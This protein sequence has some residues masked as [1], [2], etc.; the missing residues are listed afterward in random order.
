M[1]NS[2]EDIAEPDSAAALPKADSP[3]AVKALPESELPRL[4][5]NIRRTLIESLA[6]TGG[7]WARIWGSSSCA[8]R[9]T[10]FSKR[11]RTSSFST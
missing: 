4:A 3:E 9:C 5:E 2:S 11:R 7:I 6:V 8:S 10:G 1:P